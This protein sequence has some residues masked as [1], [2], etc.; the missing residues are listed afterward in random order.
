MASKSGLDLDQASKPEVTSDPY[1]DN[2]I[3]K[4]HNGKVSRDHGFQGLRTQ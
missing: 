3:H 4:V 2:R 1:A